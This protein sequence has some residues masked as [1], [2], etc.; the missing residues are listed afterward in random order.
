MFPPPM[1]P[2]RSDIPVTLPP[3]I[4]PAT[5]NVSFLTFT[6]AL[7]GLDLKVLDA[8]GQGFRRPPHGALLL[9]SS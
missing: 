4:R 9:E 3:A 8:A 6:G 7:N 5:G 2:I 1:M